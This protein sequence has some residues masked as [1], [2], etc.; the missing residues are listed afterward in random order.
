MR[1]DEGS[2]SASPRAITP[3]G[4]LDLQARVAAS[5]RR[6]GT[7]HYARVM[8]DGWRRVE[9]RCAGGCRRMW[10]TALRP[11]GLDSVLQQGLPLCNAGRAGGL[12]E[13]TDILQAP[14]GV[15]PPGAPP[16]LRQQGL[17]D[18]LDPACPLPRRS[19]RRP[20]R[21]GA[22]AAGASRARARPGPRPQPR[23]PAAAGARDRRGL[24]QA[25]CAHPAAQ[26]RRRAGRP[27]RRHPPAR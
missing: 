13:R 19:S 18:D 10:G 9:A 14:Q 21:H 7:L 20:A 15:A 6:A 16:T 4:R 25:G 2:A 24:G 12:P 3:G 1:V 11:P 17:N 8:C 26:H 27:N 22:L 23:R 5:A